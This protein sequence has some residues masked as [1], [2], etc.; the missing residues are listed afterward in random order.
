VVLVNGA[1]M[2]TALSLE[3]KFYSVAEAQVQ[4]LPSVA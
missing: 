2:V 4:G 1:G 3:M